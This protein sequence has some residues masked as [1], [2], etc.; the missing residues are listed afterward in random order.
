MM[1]VHEL[2]WPEE[3]TL[4]LLLLLL[5]RVLLSSLSSTTLTPSVSLSFFHFLSLLFMSS[6]VF[7]LLNNV[8]PLSLSFI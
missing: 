2:F 1:Q 6:P 3:R 5:L 4:L 8:F 7:L